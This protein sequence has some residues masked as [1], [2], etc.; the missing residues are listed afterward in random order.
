MT[1]DLAAF[2]ETIELGRAQPARR[3]VR[4]PDLLAIH[5]PLPSGVAE[6]DRESLAPGITLVS[7]ALASRAG[8]AAQV[9]AV[10]SIG[11]GGQPLAPTGRVLVRFGEAERAETHRDAIERAGYRLAESLAHAP[12]AAW[13]ESPDGAARA[14]RDL[15]RLEAVPGVVHVEPEM[16]GRRA[17]RS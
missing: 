13:V 9:T 12:Q 6:A 15:A 8:E 5:G 7:P 14:L 11:A 2:P 17:H 10:Y 16:V 4:R 1:D 3:Y